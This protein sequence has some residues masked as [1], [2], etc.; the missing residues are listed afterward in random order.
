MAVPSTSMRL[1]HRTRDRHIALPLLL[2]WHLA[3]S[4]HVLRSISGECRQGSNKP[5]RGGK[6]GG[7]E[8]GVRVPGTISGGW[9][10][11]PLRG[12]SWHGLSHVADWYPTLTQAAGINPS[13]DRSALVPTVDG[14]SM[15]EWWISNATGPRTVV[16]GNRMAIMQTVSG[17]FKL[18]TVD[19]NLCSTKKDYALLACGPRPANSTG[20]GGWGERCSHEAPCLYNVLADEREEHLLNVSEYLQVVVAL[21]LS[22]NASIVT[23]ADP[24]YPPNIACPDW[25]FYNANGGVRRPAPVY[26]AGTVPPRPPLPPP[27]PNAFHYHYGPPG[28]LRSP[29][30]PPPQSAPPHLLL[31]VPSPVPPPAFP[32]PL[33]PRQP[34]VLSSPPSTPVRPPSPPTSPQSSPPCLGGSE[35]ALIDLNFSSAVLVHSNLGGW[36]GQDGQQPA[37]TPPTIHFGHV[38]VLPDGRWID[39]IVSNRT[40][41][42]AWNA[43]YN[44][45]TSFRG[46]TAKF[47]TINQIAP[48]NS[49]PIVDTQ[50]TFTRLRFSFVE[51]ATGV[52]VRVGLT[53]LSIFDFDIAGGDRAMECLGVSD[54]LLDSTVAVHLASQTQLLWNATRSA[55]CATQFGKANDNPTDP[56]GMGSV[57]RERTLMLA[58]RNRSHVDMT[59]RLEGCC[60]TGRSFLFAG[61]SDLLPLCHAIPAQTQPPAPAPATPPRPPSPPVPS[62][63]PRM[64]PTSLRSPPPTS[65]SPPPWLPPSLPLPC[66][67]APPPCPMPSPD[68]APAPPPPSPH[69]GAPIPDSPECPATGCIAS[70]APLLHPVASTSANCTSPA[71]QTYGAGIGIHGPFLSSNQIWLAHVLSVLNCTDTSLAAVPDGIDVRTIERIVGRAC[72]A[73]LPLVDANGTRLGP[74]DACGGR[75]EGRSGSYHM[76]Q[77]LGCLYDLDAAGHS[78][79]VGEALDAARTPLYG[80]WEDRDGRLLPVLDACGAHFGITPDSTGM[81]VYH[82]HVSG[83][84]PFTVGCYGPTA[85]SSDSPAMVSLD[86]CRALYPE[87]NNSDAVLLD[88]GIIAVT[89]AWYDP[90]CPCF[91][92]DGLNARASPD[93][94]SSMHPPLPS[95]VLPPAPAAPSLP[96][97]A[98]EEPLTCNLLAP[99]CS[100]TADHLATNTRC[101]CQ[102]VWVDDQPCPTGTT[103]WCSD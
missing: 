99:V 54:D 24:F 96:T 14:M 10:P 33:L 56:L 88:A 17:L 25:A 12:Q 84:A 22:I 69:G 100:V 74:L 16:L 92:E 44:G 80:K 48:R 68:P 1:A 39:V 102:F 42:V 40:R 87:C 60:F 70:A 82:H 51:A 23:T 5:L 15:W 21:Q 20:I 28:P 62:P 58:I 52:P 47:G 59:I 4:A 75:A 26:T 27:Q 6:N 2:P 55:Y 30:G 71:G 95:P 65:P 3:C 57:Q 83:L 29:T 36:G 9:L 94:P 46:G 91:D 45:L 78:N 72:G 35:D 18:S 50:T 8:G 11:V 77:G 37:S 31:P 89:S 7:F 103:L 49:A 98:P 73:Q 63:L 90:W 76:H 79:K 81:P 41:Y 85:D 61:R 43:A 86:E 32:P 34:T 93:H 38:G 101:S 19:L 13:D 53:H 66:P 64:P 67:W 97:R